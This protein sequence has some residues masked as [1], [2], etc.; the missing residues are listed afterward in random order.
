MSSVPSWQAFL[1]HSLATRL[2]PDTF[3]SYAEILQS[4]HPLTPAR[5]TELLLRPTSN[6]DASLDPRIP[7]YLQVLL[8]LE[9]V[10]VPSIL[11]ALLKYSTHRALNGD[12]NSTDADVSG[13]EETQTD[14][15]SKKR[16]QDGP[17]HWTNSYAAEET[18]FYRLA[19]H[20]S[21]GTAPKS[22]QEA[23]ELVLVSIQWMKSIALATQAAQPTLNLA[24]TRAEEMNAQTMALGTLLVA[25]VENGQVLHALSKGRAPKGTGKELSV[26]LSNLVSLLLQSSPQ[27]VARLEVF[28]TQTLV[29][30]EPPEKKEKDVMASGEMDEILDEGMSLGIE[31]I[32]MQEL[33][34]VNSRAGLYIYLNALVS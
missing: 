21:S 31:S 30:I 29:A 18:M 23:V 1:F 13:R 32:V 28:R 11:R 33:P 26:A 6:N 19:K 22:I 20:I 17:S 12:E 4:K 14:N 34:T 27:S 10:T 7:R 2:E 5:I 3:S 9:L 24:S 15:G 16:K 25:I 8:G